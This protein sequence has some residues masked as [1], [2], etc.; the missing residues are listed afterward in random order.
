M[1]LA[2]SQENTSLLWGDKYGLATRVLVCS[3]K[4]ALASNTWEI[5]YAI[6]ARLCILFRLP[7]SKFSQSTAEDCS[8]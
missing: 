7:I 6:H 4:V 5:W 2:V 1:G 3:R 8:A